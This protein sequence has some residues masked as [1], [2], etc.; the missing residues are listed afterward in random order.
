MSNQWPDQKRGA[1]NPQAK[2]TDAQADMMRERHDLGGVTFRQL[3]QESG[4][5]HTTIRKWLNR[6]ANT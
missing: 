2:L 5:S 3:A 1:E 4:I 6:D